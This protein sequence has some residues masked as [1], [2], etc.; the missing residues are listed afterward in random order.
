MAFETTQYKYPIINSFRESLL[1]QYSNFQS[2]KWELSEAVENEQNGM[3]VSFTISNWKSKFPDSWNGIAFGEPM[4][5]LILGSRNT[6]TCTITKNGNGTTSNGT[7]KYTV[8]CVNDP[9]P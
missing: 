2:E 9:T 8:E 5:D 7:I 4:I 6:Y 3:T 1:K